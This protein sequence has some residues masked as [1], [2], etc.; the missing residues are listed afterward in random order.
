[1]KEGTVEYTEAIQD[2]KSS[3]KYFINLDLDE[4]SQFGGQS[5]E[6][7]KHINK[8]YENR[9]FPVS[10]E[11]ANTIQ[12]NKLAQESIE[13]FTQR[14]A[15]LGIHYE[16]NQAKEILQAVSPRAKYLEGVVQEYYLKTITAE[17]TGAGL[18]RRDKVIFIGS[19]PMPITLIQLYEHFGIE[20]VG[21]EIIP[22]I[23]DL[24]E[25]LI[26]K[27]GYSDHIKIICGDHFS[28]TSTE[29]VK[30]IIVA[31]A[32]EPI[33]EIMTHLKS[34]MSP[35]TTVSYRFDLSESEENT[36]MSFTVQN[37]REPLTIDGFKTINQYKPESTANSCIEFLKLGA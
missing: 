25:K 2:I 28:I 20:S 12:T 5:K 10:L 26:E 29:K 13:R 19:G 14:Y 9:M 21:I 35:E 17:V 34:V 32:A 30:H 33:Q 7:M 18:Q 22:E 16:I 3:Y 23:A 15:Y 1:M 4:L 6:T 27:L 24:S 37:K 8:I 36:L 31:R 11:L